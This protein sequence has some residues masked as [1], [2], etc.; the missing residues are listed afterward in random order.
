MWVNKMVC[1][2]K[3]QVKLLSDKAKLPIRGSAGAAGYDLFSAV[4]VIVPARSRVLVGTDI[5]VNIPDNCYGRVAPRSG[6]ALKFGLDVG[7]GV[8]DSDYRGNVGVILF[9]HTDVDFNVELGMRIAQLIIEHISNPELVEV[10]Q[11]GSC[12]GNSFG[13][14]PST[15][16]MTTSSLS[17][18]PLSSSILLNTRDTFSNVVMDVK[19]INIGESVV[20]DNLSVRGEHGFGS[21][22]Y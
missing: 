16:S 22:G 12:Y 7:A 8:I 15:G 20:A 14:Q 13:Y 18:T 4:N 2:W 11:F 19:N 10:E 17:S 9:N 1:G 6:L 3:L 21:T 5:S